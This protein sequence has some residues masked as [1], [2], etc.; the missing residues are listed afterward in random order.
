MKP[1]KSIIILA[2]LLAFIANLPP[3]FSQTLHTPRTNLEMQLSAI[4]GVTEVFRLESTEF[5]RNSAFACARW[6]TMMTLYT[7]CLSNGF[8]L[9]TP[10]MIVPQYL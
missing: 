10:G 8:S 5:K 9:C 1:A 6:L 2:L 4:D 7:A 3:A